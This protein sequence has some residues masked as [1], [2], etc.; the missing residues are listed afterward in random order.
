MDVTATRSNGLE[1]RALIPADKS[2]SHRALLLGALAVGETK[3]RNLL[4]SEDIQATLGAIKALGIPVETQQGAQKGERVLVI[5]GGRAFSAPSHPINCGNSGTTARLLMGLITGSDV[6]VELTG[7]ASLSRRPMA[8]LTEP[9][10]L[11]G[12]EF[13][14]PATHLPFKMAGARLGALPLQWR[15]KQP[16][17]QVKSALLLAGL[18]AEGQT[19][20]T[21]P[22]ATR[23]H[24]EAMLELFGARIKRKG[25]TIYLEGPQT[26][27]AT[28]IQ[29]PTDPSSAAFAVLAATICEKSRV[30]VSDILT[31]PLRTGFYATLNKMGAKLRFAPAKQKLCGEEVANLVASSAWLVATS[32]EPFEASAM[33]DEFPALFVAASVAKGES[34]FKGLSELRVKESDRLERMANALKQCGVSLA[35]RGDDIFIT[36]GRVKGGCAIECGG[37][38]RLA[39]ALTVL[40]LVSEEPITIANADAVAT[41]FPQFYQ[42]IGALGANIAPRNSH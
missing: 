41:S 22:V 19:A 40:G 39:M 5:R 14:P 3:I 2:I 18:A 21:E 4:E 9:L 37:D 6:E 36:G 13:E 11:M 15:L 24:T 35:L 12:A 8:R 20:I 28:D 27:E 1:G 26:L 17:A 16:S 10:M 7:D 31:N 30:E 23:N 42:H 32:T 25:D 29:I 34:S 38:H 33:I